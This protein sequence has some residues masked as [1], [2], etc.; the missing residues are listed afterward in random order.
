MPR[1]RA[2]C[3]GRR[4]RPTSPRNAVALAARRTGRGLALRARGLARRGGRR[5]RGSAG[6]CEA[7]RVR[8]SRGVRPTPLT[9]PRDRPTRRHAAWVP[10]RPLTRCCVEVADDARPALALARVGRA[11]PRGRRARWCRPRPPV[12]IDGVDDRDGAGRGC[13]TGWAPVGATRRRRTWSSWP[14]DL[15]R[16]RPRR[17]VAEAWGIDVDEVVA[18]HTGREYVVAF[19]GFAPGFAY[20]H[21]AAGRVLARA[22]AGHAP[23][24]GPGRLGGAGRAV[25]PGSTRG[26][27][28]GGWRLLG[29]HRRRRCGTV[30][31]TSPR[32]C[33]R[34]PACGSCAAIDASPSLDPGRADDRAGPRPR[35]AA[36]T[37]GCRGPAPSTRPA[38]ALANRLVGNDADRG[39]R[40]R[41]R[42]GGLRLRAG[43]GATVAVTGAPVRR[44]R[45][46]VGRSRFG[47][48]RDAGPAGAVRRSGGPCAGVRSY[49]AVAGG[50]DV[51]RRCSAPART[52]TLAWVGPPP[53]GGGRRCCRSGVAGGEPRGRRH[54]RPPPRRPGRCGCVPGPAR[55]LVRPATPSTT[56]SG[57]AYTVVG[58][59]PTGSGC[60]WRGAPLGPA[61]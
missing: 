58:R 46:T 22:P 24:P 32:C 50:I 57:A 3:P 29:T 45:W 6:R 41:P 26:R 47:A 11:L 2:G 53:A 44:S 19:C 34:A 23:R 33:R 16:P 54:A 35:R 10:R 39:R 38:A 49:L 27:R 4:R 17:V 8:A 18:L 59:P 13:T 7:G 31:A 51:P 15:R 30:R 20:L 42:C 14:V 28:P 55:R 12:L 56:L 36:P 52:D 9:V 61:P 1:E 48:R 37:S 40:W 25:L 21:R 60:G 43:A 5:R